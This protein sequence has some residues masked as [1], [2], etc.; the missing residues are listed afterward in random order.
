LGERFADF[1]LAISCGSFLMSAQFTTSCLSPRAQTGEKDSRHI[2]GKRNGIPFAL[3]RKLSCARIG[4]IL[5]QVRQVDLAKTKPR[6][7]RAARFEGS[8]PLAGRH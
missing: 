2:G 3:I 6:P 4:P 8:L 7:A 5:G 1:L